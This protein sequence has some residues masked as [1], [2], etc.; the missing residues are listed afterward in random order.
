MSTDGLSTYRPDFIL[1]K[2]QSAMYHKDIGKVD[3]AGLDSNNYLA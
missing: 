3:A 1:A 2:A